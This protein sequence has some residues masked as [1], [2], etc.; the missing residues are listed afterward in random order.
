MSF[1]C[2]KAWTETED[3]AL[4]RVVN[5]IGSKS[6]TLVSIELKRSENY[7]RTGKQCRER[8][9]NHLNPKIVKTSWTNQEDD[10]IFELYQKFGR[11][12]TKIS[13]FLP[14]R[15]DNSVKNRF[16]TYLRKKL[17][18]YNS[19]R[20]HSQRIIGS[21]RS[22]LR[23]SKIADFLLSYS[24]TQD[25][26]KIPHVP[27]SIP[28]PIKVPLRQT[29]MPLNFNINCPQ[30]LSPFQNDDTILDDAKL[31]IHLLTVPSKPRTFK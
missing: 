21:I 18:S 14:G 17:R 16:Y 4:I 2:K 9:N 12:W 6:W 1:D 20:P 23:D 27:I 30:P 11:S 5:A 26:Q 8:W 29:S 28:N 31:L 13:G 22:I 7:H 24:Q 10:L 15:S 19:S 25:Y 3:M